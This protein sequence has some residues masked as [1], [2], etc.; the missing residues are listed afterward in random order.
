MNA[1]HPLHFPLDVNVE[2]PNAAELALGQRVPCARRRRPH[3][4]KR[5]H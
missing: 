2:E 3:P 4:T 1:E 5:G